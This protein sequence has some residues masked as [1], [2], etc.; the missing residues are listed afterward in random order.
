MVRSNHSASTGKEAL[1]L[2][3]VANE[4]GFRG[5]PSLSLISF[6]VSAWLR[7]QTQIRFVL[8]G[9]WNTVFG[10]ALYVG[11]DF[12]FMHVFSKRY[13]AYMSAAV[14]S[15]V[16]AT[17][18]AF[19]FHKYYTFRSTVKGRGVIIEF[20]RFYTTYIFAILVGLA[21]LPFLVEV[22]RI[23]PR[24]SGLLLLPVAMVISYFGHSRFSFKQGRSYKNPDLTTLRHLINACIIVFFVTLGW[25][26][27][28]NIRH[29][30]DLNVP[31]TYEGDGILS[32]ALIR[33]FASGEI[34]PGLFKIVSSLNAPFPANWNDY[35]YEDM[36]YFPA[37]VFVKFFGLSAGCNLY[38]LCLQI[39]GGLS[40]YA[41]TRFFRLKRDISTVAAILFALSP[42]AFWRHLAHLTVSTYWHIPFLLLVLAWCFDPSRVSLSLKQG[43]WLG[44]AVGLIAGLYNPYYWFLFLF[45]LSIILAG[46]SYRRDWHHAW[47]ISTI[48]AAAVIGFLLSNA[49]SLLFS[50]IYGRG[51]AFGRDLWGLVVWGLRLPDLM[52]PFSG[53]RIDFMNR[54]SAFYNRTYPVYL[55]GEAQTAYVGIVSLVG[56]G[57][58]SISNSVRL[59]SR[60]FEK[61]DGFYWLA[62]GVFAFGVTGGINYVLGSLGFRLLRSTNRYSI[63]FMAIG[64]FVVIE[65]FSLIRNKYL[66]VLIALLALCL[67]LFDQLPA[68]RPRVAME[69]SLARM[70]EDQAVAN[71]LQQSLLPGGKVFQL[72]VKAF[73]ETGPVHAMHDYDHFRPWLWTRNIHFSYGTMNGRGD[74][75]W[76][77]TAAAKPLGLLLG[78][79]NRYGFSALLINRGGYKDRAAE[80]SERIRALG[81]KLFIDTPDY[82]GFKLD[83]SE[84]PVVPVAAQVEYGKGFYGP[85]MDS[86]SKPGR[87]TDGD[88]YFVVREPAWL[89]AKRNRR[90][91]AVAF[92]ISATDDRSIWIEVGNRKSLVYRPGGKSERLRLEIAEDSLPAT[93]RL[94]SD[95]PA[96]LPANGGTRKL[97]FQ[98]KDLQIGE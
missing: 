54:L 32:Y 11:L 43:K 28:Y 25:C 7:H 84:K 96:V 40:F 67:G 3:S 68:P 1:F 91:I 2:D 34:Y 26:W 27:V 53:S 86:S 41:A 65:L 46:V 6:I 20:L 83:P 31:I 57:W 62:L 59:A 95:K 92:T 17:V 38:L 88:A 60:S 74:A 73:P 51:H 71:A 30:T 77:Q 29:W 44:I 75:D 61:I 69:R 72:P 81:Y 5:L 90:P 23:D 76:Q 24:I 64:L 16:L 89:A 18:N 13:F 82:Y 15:N 48:F 9:I 98:I 8:V 39:L 19:L 93:V 45:L 63:V 42:F 66:S 97:A 87:W 47:R 21:L 10:Y 80:L 55:R 78:N 36:I 33:A 58:L 50:L 79:L 12:L 56:L 70:T 49:D 94:F 14:M 22:L 52:I 35:P 37:V 4:D 85:E